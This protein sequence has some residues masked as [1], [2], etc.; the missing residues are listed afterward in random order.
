MRTIE[1]IKRKSKGNWHRVQALATELYDV[2]FSG[3]WCY[4]D[5]LK[6]AHSQI[7]KGKV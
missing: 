3:L 5:C 2:Q 4:E 7:C 6:R 1:T